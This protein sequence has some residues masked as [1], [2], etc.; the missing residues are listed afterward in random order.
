MVGDG[1]LFT[2]SLLTEYPGNVPFALNAIHWL[3]GQ[4]LR[5][6]VSAGRVTKSRRLAIT[7]EETGVLQAIS[8]GFM[9]TLV[10]LLGIGVWNSRRGR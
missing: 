8:L 2:N 9:P 7:K 6:G 10:L 1:D 5:L 3:A 4:D